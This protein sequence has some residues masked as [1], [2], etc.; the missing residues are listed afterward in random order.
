MVGAGLGKIVGAGLGKIVGA[1]LGNQFRYPPITEK[2]NPPY[3]T[4]NGKTKPALLTDKE[5]TK[6]ALIF[7]N[8]EP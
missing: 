1:G 2:Q 4:D 7:K 3:L 8:N 6:P 5:T